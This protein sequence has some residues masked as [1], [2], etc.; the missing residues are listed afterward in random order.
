MRKILSLLL[1]AIFLNFGANFVWA[2]G[3]CEPCDGT[4]CD[5]GLECLR[6]KCRGCPEGTLICNPLQAC[7]FEEIIDNIIDFIFKIAIALAPLMIVIGAFYIM[8]AGGD[9]NRVTTGKNII[10]YTLIGFAII[11]LAKGLVA[12]IKQLLGV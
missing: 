3:L 1:L 6:G 9:T 4:P 12:V 8:T 7:E 2:A 5:P 11:L 10:L